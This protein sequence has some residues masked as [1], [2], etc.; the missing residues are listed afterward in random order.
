MTVQ[1]VECLHEL[2]GN[3]T[4]FRLAQVAIILQDL[5]ELTLGELSDD[6]KLVGCLE[7][8]EQEDNVLVV[9]TFQNFD[10]L[11][12]VI[13]LLLSFATIKTNEENCKI[14]IIYCK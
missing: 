1:V 7:G 11:P 14:I 6:A 10:F 3:L 2:L 13:H 12:Q 5:K 9:Q 4:N 8:V